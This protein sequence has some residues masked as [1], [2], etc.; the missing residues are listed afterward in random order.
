[1]QDFKCSLSLT[2]D[3][4]SC[5]WVMVSPLTTRRPVLSVVGWCQAC[6]SAS[7]LSAFLLAGAEKLKTIPFGL[8]AVRGL[9]DICVLPIGCTQTTSEW[10]TRDGGRA[11]DSTAVE[12]STFLWRSFW[13]QQFPDGSCP[14]IV[15]NS[16]WCCLPLHGRGSHCLIALSRSWPY[17]WLRSNVD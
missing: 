8:P 9:P 11:P 14:I 6:I 1:M 15:T 3:S 2:D 7:L 17:Y 13:L 5:G 10:W 4:H 12:G 16:W